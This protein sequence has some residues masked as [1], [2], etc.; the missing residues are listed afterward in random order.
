MRIINFKSFEKGE[1]GRLVTHW[2]AMGYIYS[3]VSARNPYGSHNL[4][5]V[6]RKPDSIYCSEACAHGT[7]VCLSEL[8]AHAPKRAYRRVQKFISR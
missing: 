2:E 5:L 8:R 7:G 1:T 4:I 3:V 6:H